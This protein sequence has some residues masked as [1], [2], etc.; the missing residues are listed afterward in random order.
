M[1]RRFPAVPG[2]VADAVHAVEGAMRSAG[3][4]DEVIDRVTLVAGEAAGNAVEHGCEWDPGR[5]FEVTWEEADDGYWLRVEDD[6]IGLSASHIDQAALPEDPLST[7]GRGLFLIR[8]LSD[9]VRLEADG[10][11]I[12]M[13][14]VPS[15][16]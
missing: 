13:R 2:S 4:S 12:A 16:A 5:S 7:S 15:P 6:G 8:E 10:R 11:R 3:L 14:F 1:K 9:E